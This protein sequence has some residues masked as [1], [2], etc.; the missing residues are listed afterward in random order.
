MRH[1][2]NEH[3]KFVVQNGV[4]N[5]VIFAC[6]HAP[7]LRVALKLTRRGAAG[8]FRKKRNPARNSSSHALRQYLNLALSDLRELDCIRHIKVLTCV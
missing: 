1:P 4:D 8:I 6:M 2:N 7:K 5:H 3:D